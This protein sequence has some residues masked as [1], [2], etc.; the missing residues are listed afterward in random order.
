MCEGRLKVRNV[1]AKSKVNSFCS[2]LAISKNWLLVRI[3]RSCQLH[4]NDCLE[5]Y[6]G[7][8]FHPLHTGYRH[9]YV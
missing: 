2:S 1:G 6:L 5:G 9:N 7:F 8:V 3:G 4:P